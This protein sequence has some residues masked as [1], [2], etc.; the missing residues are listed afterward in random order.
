MFH[1]RIGS[2]SFPGESIYR[3]DPQLKVTYFNVV[4]GKRLDLTR[5]L[6]VVWCTGEDLD[7]FL[8]VMMDSMYLT[9]TSFPT[10]SFLL[11]TPSLSL[12][13]Y[14]RHTLGI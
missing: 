6:D 9:F 11:D 3:S 13:V 14:I 8:T 5:P 4:Y 10:L 7:L 2:V 1:G 12:C